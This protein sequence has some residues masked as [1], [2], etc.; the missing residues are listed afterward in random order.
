MRAIANTTMIRQ[1]RS[2]AISC[3]SWPIHYCNACHRQKKDW[4]MDVARD[5][6]LPAC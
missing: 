1:M 4:T 2:I 5:L 6:P 3:Q